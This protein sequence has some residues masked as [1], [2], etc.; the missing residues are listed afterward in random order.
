ML[1]NIRHR[2]GSLKKYVQEHV[3]IRSPLLLHIVII[4]SYNQ[5]KNHEHTYA[6]KHNHCLLMLINRKLE[7]MIETA[8]R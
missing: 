6:S 2:M 3:K 5:R 4:Q 8:S 7:L 1:A